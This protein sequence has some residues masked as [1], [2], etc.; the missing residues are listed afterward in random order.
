MLLKGT[1]GQVVVPDARRV[2]Q[3]LMS[4]HVPV[5]ELSG[6]QVT[7]VIFCAYDH[8]V[9]PCRERRILEGYEPE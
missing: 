5:L 3:R 4:L 9:W 6:E 7:G 2:L 8:H 1:T